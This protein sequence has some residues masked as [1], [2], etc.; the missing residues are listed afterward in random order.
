MYH[1]DMIMPS[2]PPPPKP[3]KK[4]I[5]LSVDEWRELA[6]IVPSVEEAISFEEGNE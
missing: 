2:S 5:N 6:S 4:G 3:G 1:V